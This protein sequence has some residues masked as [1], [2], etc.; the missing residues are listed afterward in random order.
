[1]QVACNHTLKSC[2]PVLQTHCLFMSRKFGTVLNII[3]YM[4]VAEHASRSNIEYIKHLNN[5]EVP[6]I[7]QFSLCSRPSW[8]VAAFNPVIISSETAN[9]FCWW[10]HMISPLLMG[11]LP[12]CPRVAISIPFVLENLGTIPSYVRL[13]SLDTSNIP[14]W[15]GLKIGTR[16]WWW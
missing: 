11:I 3:I 10:Y 4:L 8:L 13:E 7:A 12:G 14:R 16:V 5:L 15:V 2:D 9:Q 6:Y 1:M